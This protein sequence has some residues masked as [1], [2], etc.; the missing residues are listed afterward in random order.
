MQEERKAKEKL[1]EE[2]DAQIQ[3]IEG[4][5]VEAQTKITVL[6]FE[7]ADHEAAIV[8]G[9]GDMVQMKVD[10]KNAQT[11]HANYMAENKSVSESS[12]PSKSSQYTYEYS[13]SEEE[14]SK[15]RR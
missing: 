10:L 2:C 12:P 8:Q 14:P 3:A 6:K 15:K 9:A 1:R 5:V 4:R 11:L 13:S 7:R